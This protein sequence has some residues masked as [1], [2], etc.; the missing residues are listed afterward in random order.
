[1]FRE[2]HLYKVPAG[3]SNAAAAALQCGGATVFNVLDMYN[4]RPT[5]RV[6]IIGLGG[7]GHLAVQFASKWGCDVVVFSGTESK[8]EEALKLGAREF[9]C[10]KGITEFDK[11]IQPVDHL[12][13]TTSVQIPWAMYMAIMQLPGTIYPLTLSEDNLSVPYLPFLFGGLSFQGSIIAP[14]IIHRRMLEFAAFHGVRAM[15]QQY[16]LDLEGVQT[17]IDDLKAGKMKYKAVLSA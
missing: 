5:Q 13:V 11:N 6:G 10:T 16:E 12:L 7:L 14:R 9:Y 1:M 15:V 8:R 17:A 4:V 2:N 3:L